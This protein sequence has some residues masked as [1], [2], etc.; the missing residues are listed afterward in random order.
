MPGKLP[1]CAHW[2]RT[3]QHPGSKLG[4]WKKPNSTN[5]SR[6]GRRRDQ[7][8]IA[9][10][11]PIGTW[12]RIRSVPVTLGVPVPRCPKVLTGRG[13]GGM[14]RF[15]ARGVPLSRRELSAYSLT[16]LQ[17]PPQGRKPAC[18]I[19]A[20]LP[21]FYRHQRRAL[22]ANVDLPV[23]IRGGRVRTM[24]LDR[25]RSPQS[26]SMPFQRSCPSASG[27]D[28]RRHTELFSRPLTRAE[29]MRSARRRVAT[30]NVRSRP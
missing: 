23:R 8:E 16:R 28:R 20:A 14:P 25:L 29:L 11:H 5:S 18:D 24:V 9:H 3:R 13:K 19:A 21:S 10:N 17:V 4:C 12:P 6:D 1:I 26:K 15:V 30:F 7:P 27:A 22:T 2:L